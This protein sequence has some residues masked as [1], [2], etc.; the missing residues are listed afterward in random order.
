MSIDKETKH[1][2]KLTV[3]NLK[4]KKVQNLFNNFT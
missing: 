1:L 2:R 4:T 3:A